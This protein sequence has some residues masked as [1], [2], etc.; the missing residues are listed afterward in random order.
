MTG[1]PSVFLGAPLAH[2]GLHDLTGGRPENSRA[3]ILAAIEHGYGIEIDVQL[4]ADYRAMVFH[5]EDLDRLTH[6][7]GPIRAHPARALRE[8][9]LKGGGEGI[10]DLPEIL[11]LVAGR[12]AVLV[13]I[14]DQDGNMGS[15]IGPLETA[16]ALAVT[17]YQGPVAVM[18]F[19]PHSI[20][21]LAE[22]APGIP[23]GLVTSSYGASSWPYL[24]AATR[25]HLRD[26][27]DFDRVGAAFISHEADD[28][29]RARV[30]ELKEKGASVLCWT[31]KSPEQEHVARHVAQNITFEGY[32]PVPTP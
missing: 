5:D 23:R 15:D 17:G 21:K 11:S 30:A 25:D 16:V 20:A 22:L 27:P 26:I 10:P 14:K 7:T 9:T 4:S 3:A 6:K 8:M 1:L 29:S 18:S 2:R 31:I 32:L 19:N 24:P 28:L 12:V 13:E